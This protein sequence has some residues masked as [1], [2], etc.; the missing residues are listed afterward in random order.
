MKNPLNRKQIKNLRKRY[1]H[2]YL[3]GARNKATARLCDQA[4]AYLDLKD[5]EE[6]WELSI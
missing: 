1:T 4:E 2:C 3:D 6:N 5:Q